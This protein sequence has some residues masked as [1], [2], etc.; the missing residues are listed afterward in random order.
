MQSVLGSP[1]M[2]SVTTPPAMPT[3]P[4]TDPRGG[5]PPG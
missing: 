1:A 2:P 3:T 5:D 4:P